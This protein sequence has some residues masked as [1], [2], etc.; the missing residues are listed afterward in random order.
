MFRKISE[1][2][3]RLSTG[4]VALAGLIIFLLFTALV[5][6]GQSRQ[7]ESSAGGAGSPDTSFFYAPSDLYAMAEA[8]GPEGRQAYV[9]A[10]AT[11]DV[12]W[13]IAYTLF[14]GTAISWLFGKAFPPGS[15]WRLANLVPVLGLL[16]DYLENASTSLVMARY[17]ARTPV[18]D[19]LAPL[20]TA[21]KWVFVAG[22]FLV[23]VAGIIALVARRRRRR[24]AYG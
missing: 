21:A 3:H 1:R 13:P 23:L 4:R 8:Y 12:A 6:P 18:I 10:R 7:A 5:L 15:P 24:D 17:P 16:L 19:L 20:F 14:L 22:S 11:F 9:R 2:L